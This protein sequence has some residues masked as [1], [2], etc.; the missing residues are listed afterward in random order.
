MI[1]G[2]DFIITSLQSWDIAIG[3]NAKDIAKEISRHNRV[4]YV[5]TPVDML[6]YLMHSQSPDVQR[7]KTL[8]KNKKNGLRQITAN[9]WINP[10]K[11]DVPLNKND[12]F[13]KVQKRRVQEKR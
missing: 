12:A 5:N 1:T 13:Q 8:I 11:P 2:R 3:S 4:L 9:L 6:N 7:T 10:E